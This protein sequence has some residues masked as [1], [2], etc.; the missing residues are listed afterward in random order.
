M[1]RTLR[2]KEARRQIVWLHFSWEHTFKSFMLGTDL[3]MT[4]LQIE[5]EVANAFSLVGKFET[6][7]SLRNEH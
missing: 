4:G 2:R 5:F 3:S 7:E 1:T 6:V